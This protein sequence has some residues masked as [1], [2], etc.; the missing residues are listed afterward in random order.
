MIALLISSLKSPKSKSIVCKSLKNEPRQPPLEPSWGKKNTSTRQ[1][2]QNLSNQPWILHEIHFIHC[3]FLCVFVDWA[4]AAKHPSNRPF[5]PQRQSH[6]IHKTIGHLPLFSLLSTWAW[7]PHM[8]H[9]FTVDILSAMPCC[10]IEFISFLTCA[11]INTATYYSSPYHAPGTLGVWGS[12]HQIN[13]SA[14]ACEIDHPL[15]K[16]NHQHFQ[17][18]PPFV[19]QETWKYKTHQGNP[20]QVLLQKQM[21]HVRKFRIISNQHS[22]QPK[23]RMQNCNNCWHWP[24]WGLDVWAWP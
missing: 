19:Y 1:S 22:L 17:W 11:N 2:Q 10:H 15:S 12:C 18:F 4:V 6:C 13:L 9:M 14:Y 20:R 3:P 5:L 8:E 21:F 7:H 23:V 24:P 16:N